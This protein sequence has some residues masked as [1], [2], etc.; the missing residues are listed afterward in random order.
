LSHILTKQF[1]EENAANLKKEFSS[2]LKSGI[3]NLV[4]AMNQLRKDTDIEVIS[5]SHS[6]ETVRVNLD[7]SVNEHMGVAQRQ[8]GFTRK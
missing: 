5:L 2:K 3:L 7:G 1:R 8:K 4:E 6:V